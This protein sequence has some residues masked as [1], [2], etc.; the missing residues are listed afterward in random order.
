MM[1]WLGYS[2]LYGPTVDDDDNQV[3]ESATDY[4]FNV[5][6]I[7][8]F[9]AASLFI[10]TAIIDIWLVH[11]GTAASN[12]GNTFLSEEVKQE[13]VLKRYKEIVQHV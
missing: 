9:I 11:L 3:I 2:G 13:Y 4:W 7:L 6:G 1:D 8:Y 10:L 12:G 5:Y